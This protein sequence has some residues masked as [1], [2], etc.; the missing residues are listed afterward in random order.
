MLAFY[1][2]SVVGIKDGPLAKILGRE[3]TTIIYQRANA[4]AHMGVYR[5]YREDYAGLVT[6]INQAKQK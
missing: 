1:L 2:S 4:E 3:R 5:E 6:A